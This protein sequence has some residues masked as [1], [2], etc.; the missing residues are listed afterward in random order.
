MSGSVD[1]NRLDRLLSAYSTDSQR[2]SDQL[3]FILGIRGWAITLFSGVLGSTVFVQRP[4]VALLE[5]LVIGAFYW[6]EA[7][8]DAY[9]FLLF[10][11]VATL[12][13]ELVRSGV[14]PPDFTSGFEDAE[15][16]KLPR[17]YSEALFK[18]R[19]YSS[20][21]VMYLSLTVA[22]IIYLAVAG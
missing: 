13:R 22:T 12:E 6:I 18:A 17:T 3:G 2:L 20:R 21:L 14:F 1:G 15:I 5:F 19:T 9:R 16:N 10:R 8:Y 4:N 11:R 7:S